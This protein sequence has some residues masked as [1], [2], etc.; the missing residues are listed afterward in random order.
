MC[1]FDV[2]GLLTHLLLS[3]SSTSVYYRKHECELEEERVCWHKRIGTLYLH[4]T[5][6][7][8][9]EASVFYKHLACHK[10][11]STLLSNYQYCF[12]FSFLH[13]MHQSVCGC[14]DIA[15]NLTKLYFFCANLL[16]YNIYTCY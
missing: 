6:T 8:N 2:I 1:F 11:K 14:P 13:Q 10:K 4:S 16:T 7:F 12:S 3:E 9:Y 5:C 15:L